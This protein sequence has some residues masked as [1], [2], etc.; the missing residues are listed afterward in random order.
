MKLSPVAI[1]RLASDGSPSTREMGEKIGCSGV[2]VW[3][4]ESGQHPLREE[5]LERYAKAVGKSTEEL[6]RRYLQAAFS[7]HRDG[8]KAARAALHKLKAKPKRGRPAKATR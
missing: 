8:A 1:L 2:M 7:Y 5:I 3:M 4:F 6:K